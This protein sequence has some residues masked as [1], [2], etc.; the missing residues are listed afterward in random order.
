MRFFHP[1]QILSH[2]FWRCK[3]SFALDKDI[4]EH[5]TMFA[6]EEGRFEYQIGEH[7]GEAGYG[8]LV[9]CPPNT[10]FGRKVVEPLSFHF[11]HFD[12]DDTALRFAEDAIP[13]DSK[14]TLADTERLT[15]TY[16]LLKKPMRSTEE[17]SLAGKEHLLNDLWFLIAAE[18]EALD[19][20]RPIDQVDDATMQEAMEWILEYVYQPFSLRTLADHLRL[21]PVQLTRRFRAAFGKAPLDYVTDQRLHKASHLL[22]E[23]SLSLEHIA[24]QCGYENG[25]YL[26]RVFTKRKGVNPSQYRKMNRV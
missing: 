24:Q 4:Y 14:H 1:A 5:W 9:I 22:E 17:L 7:S 21:T 20:K 23:T 19:L 3:E 16:R 10:W 15:S 25:F 13:L 6:V 8:D 18:R 2:V 26:S 11:F 12:W